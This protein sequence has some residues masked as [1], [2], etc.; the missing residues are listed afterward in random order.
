MAFK[1]FG[2]KLFEWQAESRVNKARIIALFLT[3]R[4]RESY[5]AEGLD[6]K[7]KTDK[8]GKGASSLRGLMSAM[9]I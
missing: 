9:G 4:V 2:Y 1:E 5:E 8:D 3:M 7:S 6:E